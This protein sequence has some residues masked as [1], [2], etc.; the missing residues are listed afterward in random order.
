MQYER[1][2]MRKRDGK[3]VLGKPSI[4]NL[5]FLHLDTFRMSTLVERLIGHTKRNVLE[6]NPTSDSFDDLTSWNDLSGDDTDYFDSCTVPEQDLYLFT[7][8]IDNIRKLGAT[9]NSSDLGGSPPKAKCIEYMTPYVFIANLNEGGL[10]IPTKGAWCDTGDPETWIGNNAGSHL[11]T[12]D[13][14]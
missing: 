14:T 13:P 8:Y 1:G 9:G 4:A 6:Y 11:F 10:A 2:R 3:S 5:D 7:N 12:D